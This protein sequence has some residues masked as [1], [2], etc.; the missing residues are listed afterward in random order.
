MT[1]CETG[2][3]GIC[4]RGACIIVGL[5]DFNAEAVY[6]AATIKRNFKELGV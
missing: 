2:R 5:D 3:F 1:I 6:L 4:A